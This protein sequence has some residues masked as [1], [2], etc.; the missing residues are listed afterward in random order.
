MLVRDILEETPVDFPTVVTDDPASRAAEVM[1]ESDVRA[2]PV[3]EG[4]RLVGIVTD[5]DIVDAFAQ[6]GAELAT[7]PVSGIM[8]S[9]NLITID[10]ESSAIDASR[11]LA[12]HRIHHLPVL[13]D[14]KYRGVV[15][16]GLEWSEEGMLAP[17]VRPT[18]TARHP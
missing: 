6:R 8:T 7:L 12:E 13:E 16:L 18:L 15:C 9:E 2:V 5:W 14:G 4:E 1:R 11:L 3:V 17:P 10:I